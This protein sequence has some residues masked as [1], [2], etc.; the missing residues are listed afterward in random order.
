MARWKKP[1]KEET[2]MLRRE[3]V[4]RARAGTLRFPEAVEQIRKSFGM[5]QEQF[6]TMLGMTR[7]QVADIENGRANPTLE[8]LQKIGKLFGFTVGFVPDEPDEDRLA[9]RT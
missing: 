1:T 2:R 4:T 6:G 9:P 3:L 8:T 5:T 7:R